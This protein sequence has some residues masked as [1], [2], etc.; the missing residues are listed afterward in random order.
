[1]KKQV[2]EIHKLTVI[3]YKYFEDDGIKKPILSMNVQEDQTVHPETNLL[4]HLSINFWINFVPPCLVSTGL[5]LLPAASVSVPLA[6]CPTAQSGNESTLSSVTA[7]KYS[8]MQLICPLHSSICS[9]T[10]NHSF[11]LAA[12]TPNDTSSIIPCLQRCHHY[13]PYCCVILIL[14]KHSRLLIQLICGLLP[15]LFFTSE[16]SPFTPCLLSILKDA[17]GS[18]LCM[19]YELSEDLALWMR[20]FHSILHHMDLV[21]KNECIHNVKAEVLTEKLNKTKGEKTPFRPIAG[22]IC[23]QKDKL[24]AVH[25]GHYA[26]GLCIAVLNTS[27]QKRFWDL[28]LSTTFQKKTEQH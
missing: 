3:Y 19:A 14:H 28:F 20:G 18:L 23:C 27:T 8:S 12:L 22:M 13:P 5:W 2:T 4:S 25:R 10:V 17:P 6:L 26:S 15:T 21:K 16:I 24:Y 7:L 1:M 11:S 9:S